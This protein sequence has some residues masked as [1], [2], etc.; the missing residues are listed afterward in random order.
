VRPVYSLKVSNRESSHEN[1]PD[2]GIAF[3]PR[4]FTAEQLLQ[5][6]QSELGS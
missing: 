6:I 4:H 1:I 3:L 5:K 2:P